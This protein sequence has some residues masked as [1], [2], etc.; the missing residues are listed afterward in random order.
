M[1]LGDRAARALDVRAG[2]RV[3]AVQEQDTRPHADRQLVLTVEIMIEA[4]EEEF[5]DARF[6]SRL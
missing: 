5:L 1:P 6:A 3:A 4:G 2:P